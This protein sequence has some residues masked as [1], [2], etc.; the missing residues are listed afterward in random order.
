MIEF[1]IAKRKKIVPCDQIEAVIKDNLNKNVFHGNS[2]INLPSEKLEDLNKFEDLIYSITISEI[3]V[4]LIRC[5]KN[6]KLSL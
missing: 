6:L 3:P 5:L 2:M 1:E 4:S